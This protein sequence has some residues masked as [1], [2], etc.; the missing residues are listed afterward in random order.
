MWQLAEHIPVIGFNNARFAKYQNVGIAEPYADS[1]YTYDGDLTIKAY[2][3][4]PP[5]NLYTRVYT[6]NMLGNHSYSIG[7]NT[8]WIGY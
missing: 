8:F 7:I 6:H 5:Y 2:G 4:H 3:I 1:T